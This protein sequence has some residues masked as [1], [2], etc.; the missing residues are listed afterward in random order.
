M[1]P[2]SML[3]AEEYVRSLNKTLQPIVAEALV[4]I[5]R[6]KPAD[7]IAELGRLLLDA[8]LRSSRLNWWESSS[9]SF[10]VTHANWDV[11]HRKPFVSHATP[12]A[13]TATPAA[14]AAAPE[15]GAATS[16]KMEKAEARLPDL[17]ALLEAHEPPL[18]P[19]QSAFCSDGTLLRY[20]SS[21]S[22]VSKAH[23]SLLS[24]LKWRASKGF[25]SF[26]FSNPRCC[27]HCAKDDTAHC[28]FSI[29]TDSRGWEI[30][31]CC[32]PRGRMKDPPSASAHFLK[33]I[34]SALERAPVP[35]TGECLL[36][37][38]LHLPYRR[39]P[40]PCLLSP[41][42]PHRLPSPLLPSQANSFSLS[43]FTALVSAISI[44]LPRL[45][46]S[47]PSSR[48]T[49]AASPNAFYSTRRGHSR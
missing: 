48:T 24:T 35:G 45:H 49:P 47:P 42:P 9:T 37:V 32:P 19:G 44:Q 43:T 33:T 6:E 41:P 25:D 10:F 5:A 7:P 28:V 29:G 11:K 30:V 31:Y 38:D 4:R 27:E 23:S 12:T 39:L 46:A 22:S 16:A 3:P 18:L 8:S 40:S 15:R 36:A 20:L 2:A 14:T 13:A 26:T 17:R 1:Q 34:E 21:S